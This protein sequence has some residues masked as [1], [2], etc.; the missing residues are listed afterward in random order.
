MAQAGTTRG[1]SVRQP[2]V[3][4]DMRRDLRGVRNGRHAKDL[5]CF[6][7]TVSGER[8]GISDIVGI[9]R[10][11]SP[12]KDWGIHGIIDQEAHSGWCGDENAHEIY[13]CSAS[14]RGLVNSRAVHFELISDI[15]K[16]PT[17]RARREAWQ[18]E[19]RDRQIEKCARWC[20]FLHEDGPKFGVRVPLV[21]S[22]SERPGI[23]THW[24][25]TERW[26]NGLGHWDCWPAHKGGHFP[27]LE[28]I[29]RARQLKEEGGWR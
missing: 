2:R 6:H 23:T 28:I 10:Y 7:E 20:L 29:Y 22:D 25:V 15:P 12:E 13:F 9:S 4:Y 11:L 5:I 27:I 19:E 8:R 16:L 17:L 24:D 26:L 21:Y 3:D 14:G 1:A 18:E